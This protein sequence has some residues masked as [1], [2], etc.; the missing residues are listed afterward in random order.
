MRVLHLDIETYSD[1]DLKKFGV[2]KYIE[3]PVFEIMMCTWSLDG[4]KTQVT[5]DMEDLRGYIED[6]NVLKVAHNAQFERLCFSAHFGMPVGTYFDPEPWEDTAAIAAECGYPRSLGPL[7]VALGAEE[8][9]EAGTA[10]INWFCKPDRN[11]NRR[12]PQDHPEKWAQFVAYGIQDTDTLRDVHR[13]LPGWPSQAE[14]DTFIVDQR[15]NDRGIKVDREMAAKAIEADEGGR[16]EAGEELKALLQIDNPGSLPQISKALGELGL[17]LPDMR[18][19]TLVEALK[20]DLDDVQRRALELRQLTALVAARKYAAALGSCSE[21]GRLRGQFRF[22]GAHT[23][24]WSSRGVQIQNMPRATLALPDG[25]ITDTMPDERKEEIKALFVVA[26]ILD[27]MMGSDMEPETLKALVRSLFVGP[28]TVVDYSS[29][30]AR[31]LA[32]LAGEKWV[33]DA[34]RDK[35]DIYM[36]TA[37]RMSTQDRPMTRQH[38]KV[39][40]LAL[41]YEGGVNALRHMGADG[42]DEELMVLRN[43]WREANPR[44]KRM[45][46]TTNR[47]FVEGGT[48]GKILIEKKNRGRDRHIILPSGRPLVY[49]GVKVQGSG[50]EQRITFD[51]PK[52]FRTDTYGGRLVENITQAVSRDVL[53]EALV[54]LDRSGYPVV[55]HVHDEAI[56]DGEAPV[57]EISRIM[58]KLPSWA[59]GLPLDAEGFVTQRY[60]KG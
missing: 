53:A 57:D 12:M 55:G 34:I 3:S 37:K 5:F 32:W 41:G 52:G 40:V 14:R 21:D 13:K 6:P 49:H 20:T 25:V 28:F 19:D 9:D 7:A 47:A 27:L 35:R 38:G 26:H 59:N 51:D 17:V 33:L 24:R 36:E 50:Y 54:A 11:G 56:V 15:I 1:V 44:I 29:I 43:A 45:W 39:A 16:A 31:V 23:G 42:T 30:E 60:R 4:S 18:A 58:C 46:A 2:Y 8:K 48:V 22:F 10:L